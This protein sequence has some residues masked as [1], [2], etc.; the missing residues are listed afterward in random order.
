MNKHF[1]EID[2]TTL[3][4]EDI[5]SV[6]RYSC[7]YEDKDEPSRKIWKSRIKMSSGD[8]YHIPEKK[9]E[10]LRDILLKYTKD[11]EIKNIN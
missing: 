9:Y 11:N 10:E 6:N 3:S 7:W 5:E 2:D 1:I 8:Y 4:I